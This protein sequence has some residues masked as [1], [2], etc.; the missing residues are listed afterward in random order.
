M[1]AP[2]GRARCLPGRRAT[3]AREVPTETTA[4]VGTVSRYSNGYQVQAA[5]QAASVPHHGNAPPSSAAHV[6]RTTDA[7]SSPLNAPTPRKTHPTE[8][9]GRRVVRTI[10]TATSAIMGTMKNGF[11][12]S[13]NWGQIKS[14]PRVVKETRHH[15]T[16]RWMA[17]MIPAATEGES[18]R[19]SGLR[20]T[21][22]LGV[23]T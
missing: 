21:T 16:T 13:E 12:A 11:W 20:G 6:V 4:K 23:G 2:A 18:P 7:I 15:H 9:S 8:F 10:P 22:S 19:R 3:S 17:L 1:P 5:N 14:A